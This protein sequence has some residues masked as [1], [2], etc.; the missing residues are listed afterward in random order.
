MSLIAKT[1]TPPYYAVI[2]SSHKT[3]DSE[4]Y[5]EKTWELPFPT[6]PI[7]NRSADGNKMPSIAWRRNRA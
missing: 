2:F 1:P 7:S 5:D 3:D 4:G 6:G